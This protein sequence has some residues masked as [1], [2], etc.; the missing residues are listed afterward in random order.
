MRKGV[1]KLANE[2]PSCALIMCDLESHPKGGTLGLLAEF[3]VQTA[4]SGSF[5]CCA[6][7]LSAGAG[8][9]AT[10]NSLLGTVS[11]ADIAQNFCKR[12]GLDDCE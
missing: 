9:M 1:K 6:P 2:A 10:T 7:S 5:F 11:E 3:R 12:R 8:I 4:P